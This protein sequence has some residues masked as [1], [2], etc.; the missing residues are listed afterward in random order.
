MP[1]VSV[2]AE[3]KAIDLRNFIKDSPAIKVDQNLPLLSANLPLLCTGK[4]LS[5][6]FPQKFHKI[7]Y[8]YIP[9]LGKIGV[10]ND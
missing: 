10:N 7:Y 6:L 8:L 5:E 9:I 3:I 2:R 1:K 4:V